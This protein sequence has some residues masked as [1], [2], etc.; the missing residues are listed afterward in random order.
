LVGCILLSLILTTV[1]RNPVMGAAP[2][3]TSL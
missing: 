3:V 2:A 1:R